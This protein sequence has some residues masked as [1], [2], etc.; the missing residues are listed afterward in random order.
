MEIAKLSDAE[1]R[2]RSMIQ[3]ILDGMIT[4]DANGNIRSM[5]PAAEK[6]TGF[7]SGEAV[8]T[9]LTGVVKIINEETRSEVRNPVEKVMETGTVVGLANHSVLVSKDGNEVP[10]DDSAAP[11]KDKGEIKGVILVIADVTQRKLAERSKRERE[12]M[13][14][15]VE[16]Q[17]AER[18]RIARDLHDH[19][20]QRMTGL[21]LKLEALTDKCS[22]SV[23]LEEAVEDVKWAAAEIDGDIGYLSWELRP[24]ELETL[25]L[26][27][28]LK[29][30]VR[31]WSRQYNISAEFQTST[32]DSQNHGLRLPESVETNLYRITQEGLNN[33]LKHAQAKHTSVLLQHQSD[34]VT[35][36]IEDDGNGFDPYAVRNGSGPSGLG[37]VGMKERASIMNGT[38]ELDSEVGLG[39]TVVIR[40]PVESVSTAAS[41]VAT[42]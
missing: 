11:I 31:E 18:S 13:Q 8:G 16:A 2:I 3:S 23:E 32:T 10:I 39:T 17:E 38:L 26:A 30:F 25:G 36:I 6:L 37:L 4:V 5:N 15:V 20:G 27:D 42:Y 33:V 19:L 22:G 40:V 41:A 7:V 29:S 9:R 14:G 12:M 28:A 1:I 21:R 35:L 34:A 24:T